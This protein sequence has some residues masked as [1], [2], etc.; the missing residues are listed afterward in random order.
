MRQTSH[1]AATGQLRS[2]YQKILQNSTPSHIR[3]HG[4]HENLLYCL[5]HPFLTTM[6]QVENRLTK[7]ARSLC[8][9]DLELPHKLSFAFGWPSNDWVLI[10][11][12]SKPKETLG[13]R[14]QNCVGDFGP[15]QLIFCGLILFHQRSTLC[16]GWRA[17]KLS[18]YIRHP[19]WANRQAVF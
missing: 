4:E 13:I 16:A 10:L 17:V 11:G 2:G 12:G 1:L 5:P 19:H 15:V 9:V 6:K 14:H 8:Q 3:F 7:M 18:H